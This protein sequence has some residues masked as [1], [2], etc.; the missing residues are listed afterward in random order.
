MITKPRGFFAAGMACGIKRS[1]KPDL[2]LIVS[3]VPATAAAVFTSNQYKAAP[4]LISMQQIMSGRCRAIIANAG[5]ANCGTGKH[6]LIDAKHMILE[7]ARALCIDPRQVL[8]TSTG[9]IGKLLPMN[10][11]IPGIRAL[12]QKLSKAG[13]RMAARAILTTDT[14]AKEI[15]VKVSGFTVAGIA[16]G[17]GMIHPNLAP[18]TGS[19][20]A[21]MHAFI[22]TDA[23]VDRGLLQ[24]LLKQAVDKSFNMITVD[25]CQSTNDCVFALANGLS[26]IRITCPSGRRAHYALRGFDKAL[27]SVCIY[28]AK[29][30]A[31]DGE[32]ATQL[33]EV[34]V[35][36]ARNEKEARLA[37][38]AIAGSDLLKC[39]IY[40]RDYNLG[41]VLAAAGAS[42]ARINPAK[43]KADIKFGNKT[44]LVSCD[45]GVGRARATAWGCDLTEG[46]IKINARYHT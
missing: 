36:G 30:I 1:G 29:E 14:R 32:G 11:I 26:G 17:S 20:Q 18:S 5:N 43:I 35:T 41:R 44:S 16:K 22:T 25:Q 38:R 42:K 33:I 27:E 40:G 23:K 8:I 34:R 21:T 12:S 28:L 15:A 4:I 13:G 37:A 9:S 46:Y 3:E 31:R 45:L 19:G 39:A 10:K 2:A 24:R 6:G 7:T